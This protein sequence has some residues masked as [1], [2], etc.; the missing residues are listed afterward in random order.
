MLQKQR[1]HTSHPP[2]FICLPKPLFAQSCLLVGSSRADLGVIFSLAQQGAPC[3]AV[4]HPSSEKGLEISGVHS[5]SVPFCQGFLTLCNTGTDSL[6]CH[7]LLVWDQ[8]QHI[9]PICSQAFIPHPGIPGFIMS[10]CTVNVFFVKLY[11]SVLEAPVEF[12]PALAVFN[13]GAA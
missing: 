6:H 9:H 2:A 12:I 7:L 3:P 1:P 4:C 10:L 8:K 5:D 11:L 13:P